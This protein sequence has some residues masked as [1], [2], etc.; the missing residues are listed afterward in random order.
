MNGASLSDVAM[1][2]PSAAG[3]SGLRRW[4][5]AIA[6]VAV[7]MAAGFVLRLGSIEYLLLG[8][9]LTIAFQRFVRRQPLRAAWVRGAPPLTL[10]RTLVVL[11]VLLAIAPCVS[12]FFNLRSGAWRA[13]S[14]SL[15]GIGGALGAAYA[16]RNARRDT[17]WALLGCVA[18]AGVIGSLIMSA[19]LLGAVVTGERAAPSL[20]SA[21]HDGGRALL[22]FVPITFALEEVSFRGVLDAHVRPAV[23]RGHARGGWLSAIALSAIW[24]LWHLPIVKTGGAGWAGRA[25]SLVVVHTL[26]GVPLSLW[27]R[28]SDNLFVPAFTHALIDAVRDGL[29]D[30]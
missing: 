4:S 13:A 23:E 19:A 30:G 12:L 11:A 1:D 24:G 29:L 6:L 8:I 18:T 22:L 25:I 3:A 26:I 21:L 17:R 2:G 5:E 14:W 16:L 20:R 27:W 9:P 28:R 15:A 7:W 10:D